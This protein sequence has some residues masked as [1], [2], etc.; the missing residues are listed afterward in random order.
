MKKIITVIT[1]LSMCVSAFVSVAAA[2]AVI[3][4]PVLKYDFEAMDGSNLTYNTIPEKEYAMT[5]AVA[6]QY[7]VK[8]DALNYPSK[9][10][11]ASEGNGYASFKTT[12]DS[13]IT[14]KINSSKQLSVS[15][16]FNVG[17]NNITGS[18]FPIFSL[19]TGEPNNNAKPYITAW[20]SYSE[21]YIRVYVLGTDSQESEK[22]QSFVYSVA[23]FE[24]EQWYH[25]AMSYDISTN[26]PPILLLNG[27]KIDCYSM[28]PTNAF[29][30]APVQLPENVDLYLA[31]GV[32]GIDATY[33]LHHAGAG[34]ASFSMY[35]K[36]LSASELSELYNND[37][38]WLEPEYNITVTDGLG[39]FVSRE[40]LGSVYKSDGH[41][42][43]IAIDFD[44]IA[45]TD[46]AS[47]NTNTVKI[48][49]KD[50]DQ[51]I[52]YEPQVTENQY[53]ITC[54]SIDSGNYRLEI[55][56]IKNIQGEMIRKSAQY[57]NFSVFCEELPQL[58]AQ[59]DMKNNLNKVDTDKYALSSQNFTTVNTY[60]GDDNVYRIYGKVNDLNSTGNN[61]AK[62]EIKEISKNLN[63]AFIYDAW[64]Y[65]IGDGPQVIFSVTGDGQS[66]G[67]YSDICTYKQLNNGNEYIQLTDL[68]RTSTDGNIT[69]KV[70][71][72]KNT[73]AK[74]KRSSWNHV[75][76]EYKPDSAEQIVYINGEKY[77]LSADGAIPTGYTVA[78]I[79]DSAVFRYNCDINRSSATINGYVWGPTY[80]GSPSRFRFSNMSIYTGT[81]D[82][83]ANY[84]STLN[85]DKYSADFDI[86]LYQNDALIIKEA[87]NTILPGSITAKINMETPSNLDGNIR[88][89]DEMGE[90]IPGTVTNT[91]AREVTVVF[92][93]IEFG[94]YKLVISKDAIGLDEDYILPLTIDQ[95]TNIVLDKSE[96]SVKAAAVLSAKIK[97]A[98]LVIA[99]YNSNGYLKEVKLSSDIK[100]YGMETD[101]I[102]ISEGDTV[103]AMLWDSIQ[104]MKPLADYKD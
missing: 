14:S 27:E 79:P 94:D 22:V 2:D 74:L 9:K 29:D 52:I 97:T 5:V 66:N 68:Y 57:L 102:A 32:T 91:N 73:S 62:G 45:D 98:V 83:F 8:G 3:P 48:Y 65:N 55:D 103:K 16:M 25:F 28:T 36:A 30:G 39:A 85:A 38:T 31:R 4:D 37:K 23:P 70:I 77:V 100:D 43:S 56:G 92:N 58:I 35:N 99:S 78:E 40:N 75:V 6:K 87:F 61:D 101:A 26:Q 80:G 90:E 95:E 12:I 34:Y 1:A 54:D 11:I 19:L 20:Y 63:Q 47:F 93:G 89:T 7:N 104:G 49:D 59:Y 21:K 53:I 72:Y 84:L 76:L 81:A 67:S 69:D 86:Q 17:K 10:Y 41:I 33:W 88:I 50:S 44:T 46:K 42:P 51:Y 96:A 13:D 15:A 71:A 64:F 24:S 82:V 60:F 18:G